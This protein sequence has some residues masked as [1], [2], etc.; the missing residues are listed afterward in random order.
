MF[1]TFT[2]DFEVGLINAFHYV[3][4]QNENISHIRYYFHYL[5]NIRRYLQK[6]GFTCD[7]YIDIYDLFMK[8]YKS[9]PFISLKGDKLENYIKKQFKQYSNELNDFILYFKQMW[10]KYFVN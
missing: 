3:F 6:D 8:I 9:I 7:K 5:R 4:N 1:K 10:M 2:T